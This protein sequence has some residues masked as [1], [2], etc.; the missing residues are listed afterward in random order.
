MKRLL[1]ITLLMS[2]VIGGFAQKPSLI[3]TYNAYFERNY[4]KAKELID[5][6]ALDEKLTT[7]AQTWL[8]MGNIYLY[9]ANEEYMAK[10]QN[11]AYT[12]KYP[13]APEIAYDAFAKANQMNKNVESSEMLTPSEG[14]SRLYTLMLIYGVEEIIAKNYDNGERVLRKAI[15]SYEM[16]TPPEYPLNG[17]LYYYY[18][19]TL[20]ML[21][22]PDDARN[23]YEKAINDHSTNPSVYLRLI[24]QY[25]NEGKDVKV[26][27]IINSGKVSLPDNPNIL[28]AEVDYFWEKDPAKAK[29]LLQNLP[30]SLMTNSDALT[31]VA[32]IYI[33]DNDLLNAEGY[34]KKAERLTPDNFIVIYNLGYCYLKLYDEKFVKGN[35]LAVAGNKE[36][37]D[38]VNNEAKK[39]L[40]NAEIY[41]EKAIRI[42]PDDL[43]ILEQL[44]EIYA[45]KKSPKYEEILE[46]INSIKQ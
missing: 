13:N 33:K 31:N 7:K 43:S 12:I 15:E 36:E 37:A 27:E 4:E 39:F 28:V 32:N 45:R 10:Q 19:Y 26:L 8:Y 44:K 6:C 29:Q 1:S 30:P 14:M 21:N 23:F 3:K 38:V 22:R 41:F 5:Q 24:E 18:A 16:K 20:E 46:K 2:I 11:E 34:L 17:E 25:K 9:L 40:D 35:E 42:E